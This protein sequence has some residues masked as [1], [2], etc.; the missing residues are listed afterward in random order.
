MSSPHHKSPHN[1]KHTIFNHLSIIY[2]WKNVILY[3]FHFIL[4]IV[5]D[6]AQV[7]LLYRVK[8]F[9]II[10]LRSYQGNSSEVAA[11]GFCNINPLRLTDYKIVTCKLSLL[12]TLQIDRLLH[13]YTT[14][15]VMHGCHFAPECSPHASWG[16]EGEN[17]V[18]WKLNQGR[19]KEPD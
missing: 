11:Q 15:W 9:E 4:C 8:T 1:N 18:F 19:L 17:N 16:G 6:A 7:S 5:V 2:R 3:S 12:Q 14:T 13:L 10:P